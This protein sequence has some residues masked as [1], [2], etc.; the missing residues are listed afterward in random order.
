MTDVHLPDPTQ[1]F[2]QLGDSLVHAAESQRQLVEEVSG[3][4][5]DEGVRFANLRLERNRATFDK[6]QHCHGIPGLMGVQQEWLRDCLQD[7]A[8]QSMR[9]MTAMRGLTK[10][11]MTSAVETASDNIDRMQ[12]EAGETMH[13]AEDAM[14]QAGEQMSHMVQDANTYIQETQH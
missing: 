11:M 14:E 9:M 7:Y 13:R 6:L 5:K 8:S 10:N 12:K 3:F 4:A 1:A 2:S